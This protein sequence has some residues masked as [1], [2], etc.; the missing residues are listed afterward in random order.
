MK[1]LSLALTF[2]MSLILLI[3]CTSEKN[4]TSKNHETI[5]TPSSTSSSP[6]IDEIKGGKENNYDFVDFWEIDYKA[7][8]NINDIVGYY[9]FPDSPETPIKIYSDGRYTRILRASQ[10]PMEEAAHSS[11]IEF[12]FDEN[13]EVQTNPFYTNNGEYNT[14]SQG[15][16][17]EKNG[18]YFLVPLS[19]SSDL[20]LDDKAEATY[21][22]TDTLQDKDEMSNILKDTSKFSEYSFIKNGVFFNSADGET[23][24]SSIKKSGNPDLETLL[25]SKPLLLHNK[26]FPITTINQLYSRR[27]NINVSDLVALTPKELDSI[28]FDKISRDSKEKLKF[29]FKYSTSVV[30]KIFATDGDYIYDVSEDQLGLHAE[31]QSVIPK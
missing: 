22:F 3:G 14:L 7:P 15:R 9:E 19:Y 10:A 8:Q 20:Y 26:P 30:D 6:T 23:D 16:V 31:R 29:G 2:G 28:D 27:N 18:I 5:Q 24:E 1:K 12:Y 25:D 13:N 21:V 4:P 11:K 17:V